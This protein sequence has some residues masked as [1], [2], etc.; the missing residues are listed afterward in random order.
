M[1]DIYIRV[2]RLGERAED[3][4]TEVYEE[5]CRSW[6]ANHGIIVD[7]VEKD[8]DI[9]GTVAVA[10]RKLE[11]LVQKVEAGESEGIITPFLDRF[12]RDTIEGAL[13]YRRIKLAE[14]RLV[15]VED[16]TDSDR[17]GDQ[18][19]FNIRMALAEDYLN[20]TR[21]NYQSAVDRKIAKG[22][23]IYKVPFGYRKD[24]D[25]RLVV[26][27]AQA[28]LVREVFE[29]RAAGDDL[30]RRTRFLRAAGAASAY[31][32][33][34]FTK[35]GLRTMISNRT[36][37]GEISV[38]NGKKGQPRVIPNYHPPIVTA[39]LFETA[40]AVKGAFHPR[41]RSLTDQSRLR[42]L[43]WCAS[44]NKRVKIGGYTASGK[45][46]ANYVC[47]YGECTAHAAMKASKLDNYVEFLLMQA[48]VAKEPHVAAVIEGNSAYTDALA[49]VE[50]TQRLH[51]EL[52]DDLAV[53]RQLGTKDW[54]AALKVRKEALRFARR[55][56]SKVR[57]ANGNGK[58]DPNRRM[59]YEEFLEEYRRES[60]A[61]FIDRVVLKP[62][63]KGKAGSKV[64][65]AERVDVYFVGA[66][67]PYRPTYKKL[68][69]RDAASLE[70][71]AADVKRR[72][73]ADLKR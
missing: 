19:N 15:C 20:R 40:N 38:Q 60:N 63:P 56:L 57:P 54:L 29:R 36:Y 23:H 65:P 27:E 21:A 7:E 5:K 46:L 4:A 58:G 44:C 16:G 70:R 62:N 66:T 3:E 61:R 22:A 59:T 39:Q 52:R 51:D 10:D 34:P 37:L 17:P 45:R 33:K 42:G 71:H 8:T 69:K 11:R 26:D 28:K 13:A 68:S 12:G 48:A 67:E 2:S 55:E 24:D 18:L 1:Y 9:S 53:Q 31:S 14:G 50:E 72:H 41:D 35:S 64:D 30:G 25:D 32:S 6:A 47:T 73:A 43:V 49:T